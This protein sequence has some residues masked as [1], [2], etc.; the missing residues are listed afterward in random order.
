[1]MAAFNVSARL[2]LLLGLVLLPPLPP[3]TVRAQEVIIDN[4]EAAKANP[5]Q[6][7]NAATELLTRGLPDEAELLLD[8]A[9]SYGADVDSVRFARAFLAQTRGDLKEAEKLYRAILVDRPD[10]LRVRLELG[11]VYYLLDDDAKAELQFRYALAGDLPEPVKDNVLAFLDRIRARRL[12]ALSLN[13]A[14]A[15]DTNVNAAPNTRSVD[16]L[17]LPF[18]LDEKAREKSDIGLELQTSGRFDVPVT[19]NLLIR[20]AAFLRILE[21]SG[22]DYDDTSLYMQAGPLWRQPGREV[23]TSILLGRRWYESHGYSRSLGT[24]VDVR[25]RINPRVEAAI[26][27]QYLYADHDEARYLDGPRYQLSSQAIWALTPQSYLRGVIALDRETA[28]AATESNWG[29]FA[30]LGYYVELPAGFGV[31]AEPGVQLRRFDKEGT[32]FGKRRED[33]TPRLSLNLRNR[34]LDLFGF[35]PLI[36]IDL[37]KRLSNI[38]LYDYQRARFVLGVTR[39]F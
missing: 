12:W 28:D 29:L 38:D 8:K 23:Q 10:A 25:Q 14:V 4:E 5:D 31:Y 2:A 17:G 18:Q 20:Q 32:A 27:L 19:D 6:L 34:K 22:A 21:Y 39:E 24:R 26:G 9:E 37:E 7:V 30:A 3:A 16:I 13:I 15:P 36:G 11:R 1:M 33:V 35:T